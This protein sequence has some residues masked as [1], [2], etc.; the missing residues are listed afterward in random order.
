MLDLDV[1]EVDDVSLSRVEVEPSMAGH[2]YLWRIAGFLGRGLP[3]SCMLLNARVGEVAHGGPEPFFSV[4]VAILV[5]SQVKIR[6]S[7][8]EGVE[9]LLDSG[10]AALQD[11]ISGSPVND[12]SF[13]GS[14]S[15]G[16]FPGW[17]PE[18]HPNST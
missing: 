3:I 5:N 13:P 6:T 2:H 4:Q 17:I 14:N 16:S 10:G 1:L 15:R 7:G 12:G 9:S 11:N 8:G 18:S